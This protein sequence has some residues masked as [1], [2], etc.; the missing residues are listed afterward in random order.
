MAEVWNNVT[1]YGPWTDIQRFK[2]ACLELEVSFATVH[3]PE[4][5]ND[6]ERDEP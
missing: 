6:P 4:G 3:L 5:S 1:V 2:R